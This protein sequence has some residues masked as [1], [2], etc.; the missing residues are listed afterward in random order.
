[1]MS[2]IPAYNAYAHQ[3][4]MP[5]MKPDVLKEI[6][7]LEARKDYSNPRY[8][9]LLMEN[10]YTDHVLRMPPEQWPNPVLRA[11]GALNKGVYIPMQ[12]PS[13]MGASGVLGAWD[14][15]ADLR[16][17]RV[18]TLVIG[19]GHD[20]MDPAHMAW[21]A[22]QVPRGRYLFCPEGSHLAMYDDQEVYMRGLVAFLQ[23][24]DAGRL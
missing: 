17:I 22:R 6:L 13:E 4:L 14:R 1:M 9:A 10:F 2:S 19:A 15:S 7:A 11:F 16:H 20:T 5:A 23:D 21:M 8:E 18:P 3:V 24:V 12:G